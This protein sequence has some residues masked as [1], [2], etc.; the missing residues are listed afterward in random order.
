ME[1]FHKFFTNKFF[2]RNLYIIFNYPKIFETNLVLEQA[3]DEESTLSEQLK[4]FNLDNKQEKSELESD[5][6]EEEKMGYMSEDTLKEDLKTKKK[7][8][9]VGK[10]EQ[11]STYLSP[12]LQSNLRATNT[13]LT[14]NIMIF[15]EL[16][17]EN[18]DTNR[19]TGN[20]DFDQDVFVPY[21]Y[22]EK[23]SESED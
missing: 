3:I 14:E 2:D 22:N 15:E 8:S 4:E 20:L 1:Y 12:H 6:P 7:E 16:I 19:T 5:Y 18:A 17:K 10:I 11:F 23:N 21:T 13:E 9:F